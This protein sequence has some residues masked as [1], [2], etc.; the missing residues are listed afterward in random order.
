MR[1]LNNGDDDL[2]VAT[3]IF[4]EGVDIPELKS[5]V[6]AAGGSSSIQALQRIGRGM[7]RTD[8]KSRFYVY[9]LLDSGQRWMERHAKARQRAYRS[10][11]HTVNVK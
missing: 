1:R 3:N 8:S 11:G 10:E 4:N 6:I 5:V 2:L 9:D 7:R